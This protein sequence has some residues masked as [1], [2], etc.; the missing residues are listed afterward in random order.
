MRIFVALISLAFL[1]MTVAC[2]DRSGLAIEADLVILGGT[3]YTVDD[4]QLR[5]EAI[6]SK[7][8]YIIAAGSEDEVRGVIGDGT[9]VINLDGAVAVPGLIEGHAHLLSL[10]TAQTQ[11]ALASAGEWQEIVDLVAEAV[12]RAEPGEWILGRGWHQEKWGSP[13]ADSLDGFPVHF[14]LS[15][16]AGANPVR[17]T[18]AS[19][20]AVIVNA[21]AMEM[22]G[23]TDETPDPE[24]GEIVRDRMGKATGVLS[25]TAEEL[26][27]PFIDRFGSDDLYRKRV[28]L[29]VEECLAKGITSFQD[30]GSSLREADELLRMASDGELRIRLWI[31]LSEDNDVLAPEL[32]SHRLTDAG[33]GF[34]TVGGIKRWIDGALGSRGAWLLEPYSDLPATSGLNTEDLDSMR[35]TARLALEHGYQFCVHAI[36]DRANRETLDLFEEA[37]SEVPEAQDLRWRIEHAQHLDSS[38]IG[39]FSELGIIASMQPT[40]CVS[41]GPWVPQRLGDERSEQGAYVWR[42]LIDS[43]AVV[44][45]GTDAPVEDVDPL[46]T[47]HAAITRLMS[48]GEAFYPSQCMTRIEALEA[49]TINAAYAVFQDDVKGTLEVGKYMDVTVLTHDILSV[50]ES[51]VLETDVLYTIVGGRIQYSE[52]HGDY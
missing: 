31:M 23:I 34:L 35:E 49:A 39:R 43:G 22:A 32:A 27:S 18:H 15:R 13:P 28:N 6:A 26:L 11:L 20:H 52:S 46:A 4:A 19:G 24:G 7:G 29:A 10:G 5:V 38:D 30:A 51:E 48:N 40:H 47:F 12:Q 8:Q 41:D 42:R 1:L 17:L 33:D 45:S 9:R 37:F 44:S 16:V 25:E 2:A 3:I 21:K 36:G 50:P 14:D